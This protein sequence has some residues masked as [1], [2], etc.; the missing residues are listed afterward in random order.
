[1]DLEEVQV[2]GAIQASIDDSAEEHR[3]AATISDF[4]HTKETKT[5]SFTRAGASKKTSLPIGVCASGTYCRERDVP[6]TD[7]NFC[8]ICMKSVHT[9]CTVFDTHPSTICIMSKT[10]APTVTSASASAT[11][12]TAS[13]S[14]A[15][16]TDPPFL[17]GTFYCFYFFSNSI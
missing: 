4:T 3:N 1:M 2:A 5:P 14:I 8:F 7:S 6:I 16:I 12:S 15:P 11:V 10:V 13:T 17:N 9:G